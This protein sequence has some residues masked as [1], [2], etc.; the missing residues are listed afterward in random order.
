MFEIL[1]DKLTDSHYIHSLVE[2]QAKYDDSD[3]NPDY[4]GDA[5]EKK[6]AV[7]KPAEKKS[8]PVAKTPAPAK[9]P[10]SN[11][12]S[13]HVQASVNSTVN[14]SL[15][16]EVGGKKKHHKGGRKKG[17]K[18]EMQEGGHTRCAK[19]GENCECNGMVTYIVDD[20]S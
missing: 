8:L 12:T 19:E 18:D 13:S 11:V 20:D 14:S 17:K 15:K 9:A 1:S 6:P 2:S 5:G 10:A 7:K 16:L 3:E 4:Y